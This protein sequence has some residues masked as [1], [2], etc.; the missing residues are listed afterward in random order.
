L[1]EVF[2]A[3]RA[4]GLNTGALFSSCHKY[5]VCIIIAAPQICGHRSPLLEPVY[6]WRDAAGR[7]FEKIE[8]L[9]DWIN[10]QKCPEGHDRPLIHRAEWYIIPYVNVE[11]LL[12]KLQTVVDTSPSSSG[13]GS[14]LSTAIGS[15]GMVCPP[16]TTLLFFAAKSRYSSTET[17]LI[18]FQP[19]YTL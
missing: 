19:L 12:G 15:S 4:L 8:E 14:S 17:S 6:I 16:T 7:W 13:R 5:E 11:D 3:D 10:E 18:Q 9:E 2:L 1:T